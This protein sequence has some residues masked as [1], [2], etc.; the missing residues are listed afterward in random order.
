MTNPLNDTLEEEQRVIICEQQKEINTLKQ[1]IIQ[2][3]DMVAVENEAKYRAY[4]K[5][6]DLQKEKHDTDIRN[7]N[8]I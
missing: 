3:R 7:K 5:I 4:V 2:L 1:N 8:N 6:A